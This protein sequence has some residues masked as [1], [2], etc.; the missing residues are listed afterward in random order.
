MILLHPRPDLHDIDTVS[1]SVQKYSKTVIFERIAH[2]VTE[3]QRLFI[4]R[5]WSSFHKTAVQKHIFSHPID[6]F[7]P[8]FQLYMNRP[9]KPRHTVP[10]TPER[11]IESLIEELEQLQIQQAVVIDAILENAVG[12]QTATPTTIDATTA[13]RVASTPSTAP[14]DNQG[15]TPYR[16]SDRVGI[17]NSVRVNGR[18]SNSDADYIGVV[19]KLTKNYIHVRTRSGRLIRR[20]HTNLS[21]EQ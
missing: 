20:A 19:E 7:C 15:A 21:H 11:S 1:S 5:L 6:Y 12:G 8:N 4:E 14:P 3:Q 16:V 2:L 10:I 13:H 18:I 9:N 17:T